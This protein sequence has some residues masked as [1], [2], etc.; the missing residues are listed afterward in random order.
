MWST[1]T[2]LFSSSG[3]KT[4]G[5]IVIVLACLYFLYDYTSSKVELQKKTDELALVTNMLEQQNTTIKQLELDVGAY[6]NK[7]PEIIEKIVT[8]Y[9]IETKTINT[10]DDVVDSVFNLNSSF[11]R[12]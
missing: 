5:I 7:E 10:C 1:I 3:S 4:T 6:K 9:Q 11:F 2:S 8:K 12:K